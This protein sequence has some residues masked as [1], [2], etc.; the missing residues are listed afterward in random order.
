MTLL[1]LEY[2]N[3]DTLNFLL[4][5]ELW[6]Y[7][8]LFKSCFLHCGNSSKDVA[9]RI[10]KSIAQ[11]SSNLCK[12]TYIP[13]LTVDK[14]FTSIQISALLTCSLVISSLYVEERSK[15]GKIHNFSAKSCLIAWWVFNAKLGFHL[16]DCCAVPASLQMALESNVVL[17]AVELGMCSLLAEVSVTSL[18]Y[19]I[20]WDWK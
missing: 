8:L 20:F 11:V 7:V 4:W 6:K 19:Y 3:N 16:W 5:K 13:N 12:A 14:I 10:V 2:W 1:C 15:E 17:A 9:S 18:W